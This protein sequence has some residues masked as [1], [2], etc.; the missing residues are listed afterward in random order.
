MAAP[1]RRSSR[2]YPCIGTRAYKLATF[3]VIYA[4]NNPGEKDGEDVGWTEVNDQG[5]GAFRQ[6]LL[7]GALA[8][9]DLRGDWQGLN[10]RT[11]FRSP[12]PTKCLV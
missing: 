12:S 8:F 2:R 1:Y 9:L 6:I 3:H 4:M 5:K 11:L 7:E 10:R